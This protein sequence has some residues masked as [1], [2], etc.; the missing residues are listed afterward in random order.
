MNRN[1][2]FQARYRV[3]NATVLTVL[4]LTVLASCRSAPSE[5]RVSQMHL[6]LDP[7]GAVILQN[8]NVPL[9]NL[10]TELRRAGAG[11]R[12]TIVISIPQDTSKGTASDI[13]RTLRAAG[14]NRVLLTRPRQ[15]TAYTAEKQSPAPP[16][17]SAA[18]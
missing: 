18:P 1:R 7:N 3:L 14:F 17:G 11:P 4:C 10:A 9:Q 5:Q 6:S 12:T 2:H 13:I 16:S 15:V 8:R